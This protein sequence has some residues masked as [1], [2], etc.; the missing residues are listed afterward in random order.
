MDK[1]YRA[2]V[3]AGIIVALLA[4]GA[5]WLVR[6]LQER[7]ELVYVVRTR[8]HVDMTEQQF[9]E[10]LPGLYRDIKRLEYGHEQ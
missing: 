1:G 5:V 4:A 3:L 7:P 9:R 10:A 6:A 2:D 8:I